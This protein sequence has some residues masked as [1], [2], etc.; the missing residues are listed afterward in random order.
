[1]RGKEG[2]RSFGFLL[3]SQKGVGRWSGK[4]GEFGEGFLFQRRE[5]QLGEDENE[6]VGGSF[7]RDG[8]RVRVHFFVFFLMFQ[9]CP[10]LFLCVEGYYL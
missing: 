6:R 9:N 1:M 10:L 2:H 5:Q 4:E 8:F 3:F 7:E